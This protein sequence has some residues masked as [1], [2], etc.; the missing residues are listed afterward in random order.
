MN[1]T[2]REKIIQNVIASFQMD[3]IVVPEKTIEEVKNTL[4]K[5]PNI[6]IKEKEN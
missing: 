3:S 4:I 6:L 1:E 2:E 5:K